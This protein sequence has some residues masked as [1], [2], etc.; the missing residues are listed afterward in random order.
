MERCVRYVVILFAIVGLSIPALVASGQMQHDAAVPHDE[1]RA[2]TPAPIRTTMAALHAQGGVPRGWK[3]LM[4]PGDAAEGRKVFVAMECFACHAVK[5]EE[6]PRESKTPRSVGPD[7][8]GMGA[9]HPAKY[10]A[11]W[12]APIPVRSGPTLRGVFDSRGNSSFFTA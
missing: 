2:A 4:P 8:T 9:H 11:G 7:L 3:F 1:K 5:N 6:F 10:S 12:W